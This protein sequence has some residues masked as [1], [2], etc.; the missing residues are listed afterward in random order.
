MPMERKKTG[1]RQYTTARAPSP[2][3]S[4][5]M[6]LLSRYTRSF[7]MLTSTENYTQ[8]RRRQGRETCVTLGPRDLKALSKEWHTAVLFFFF[9]FCSTSKDEK[10]RNTLD[11]DSPDAD[12][13]TH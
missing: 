4:R 6:F 12:A 13:F 7:V 2:Q 8:R 11:I 10:K 1:E 3:N 5:Y 9:F